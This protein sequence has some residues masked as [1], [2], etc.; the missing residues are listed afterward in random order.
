MDW[1]SVYVMKSG[2]SYKVGISR[3]PEK[4][5]ESLKLGNPDIRII[6]ASDQ[7][8]NARAI[9]LALHK[10]F[11]DFKLGREWF[12]FDD[13]EAI[14]SYVLGV[15]LEFGD[16][17]K[18]SAICNNHSVPM[19]YENGLIYTLDKWLEKEDTEKER[20][21][22]ENEELQKFAYCIQGYEIPNAFSDC[23]YKVLFGMSAV[24]LRNKY[25]I[26]K[27]ANLRDCFSIEELRAVQSMECLVSGLVDCGWE[28]DQ[29]KSFIEH[30][31]AQR[32]LIA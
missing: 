9:E 16:T 29:V 10:K 13:E 2:T 27:K 23:I 28:Y 12:L 1:K 6:Y 22:W 25:G 17:R 26:D 20:I 31:N 7:I 4:R 30:T 14:L 8:K 18:E 5:L 21:Q 15:V 3:N 24:Q 11:S 32:Q 19:V